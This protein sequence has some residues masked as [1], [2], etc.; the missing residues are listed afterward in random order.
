MQKFLFVLLLFATSCGAQSG[1]KLSAD[2]FEK[3][4]NENKNAVLLD[5]R[6]GE[7]F[8][9]RHLENAVNIDFNSDS[10]GASIEKIEKN[11]AVFVYCLSGGR[12]GKAADLLREK[13][14]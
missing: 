9:E 2:E 7:E 10:F 3:Q 6:T 1:Q 4:L 14:F 5:V 11:Q 8:A 12:S 13:G